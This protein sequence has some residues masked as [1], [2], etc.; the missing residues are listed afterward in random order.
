MQRI[1][2]VYYD[3]QYLGEDTLSDTWSEAR[4]AAIETAKARTGNQDIDPTLV[5]I[6]R[7][8]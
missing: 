6:C 7:V 4:E 2:N 5:R 8:K 3:G 1:W